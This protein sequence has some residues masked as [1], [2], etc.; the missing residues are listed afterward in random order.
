LFG[1]GSLALVT[2]PGHA[3]G[4]LGLLARTDRGP[5]LFAADSCWLRRSI[6]ERRLPHPIT[7]LIV[8]D[9]R[10]VRATIERLHTFAV[11]WPE[12]VILPSHCPEAFEKEVMAWG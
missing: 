10:A 2:L 8:D 3:R 4:Q 11:A 6:R 7:N 12:V 1:D 9:P 5:V